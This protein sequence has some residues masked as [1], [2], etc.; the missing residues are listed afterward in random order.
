MMRIVAILRPFRLEQTRQLL[1]DCSGIEMITTQ[2][3]RGYGMQKGHL[4][5]YSG[6][7]VG[8]DFLPKIRLEVL[9]E[10]NSASE[11]SEAIIRGG[12]T[13]RS[14]GGK[15]FLIPESTARQG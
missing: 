5:D 7:D 1:A 8:M 9:V 4:E 12:R 3:V 6:D 15:R 11:V 2:E 13:G 14:G 10:E